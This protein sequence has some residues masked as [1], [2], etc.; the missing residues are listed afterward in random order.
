[1]SEL[2]IDALSDIAEEVEGMSEEQLK[3]ELRGVMAAEGKRKE[4]LKE[5]NARPEVAE[6]RKEYYKNPDNQ[7]KRKLY[8]KKRQARIKL[9][10]QK[11][12]DLGLDKEVDAE[13]GA[14]EGLGAEG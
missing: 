4:R 6:R 9:V 12:K 8:Q 5:Y 11:A 14:D 7:A 10:L 13:I 2:E 1:M 3:E